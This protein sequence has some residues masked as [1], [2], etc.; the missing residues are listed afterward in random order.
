MKKD[1]TNGVFRL[2]QGMSSSACQGVEASAARVS[3]HTDQLKD[4]RTGSLRPHTRILA[5][6]AALVTTP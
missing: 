3:T 4:S 2:I 5:A 1:G 6:L